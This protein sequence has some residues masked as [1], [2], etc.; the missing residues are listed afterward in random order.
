[1]M[2][3]GEKIKWVC[4][5]I[6]VFLASGILIAP[7]GLAL[8]VQIKEKATI[9]GDVILLKDIASFTPPADPRVSRLGDLELG[10]A[11]YPGQSLALN[12]RYL[13]SR[14]GLALTEYDVKVKVP[15]RLLVSRTA[16]VVDSAAIKRI[17]KHYILNNSSWPSE[18]ITLENITAP[19]KLLLPEGRLDWEVKDRNY[20]GFIGNVRLI[21]IFKVDG[22]PIRKVSVSGRVRVKQ[23]VI[24]A[25]RNLRPGDLIEQEDIRF[26]SEDMAYV[27]K[28]RMI[29]SNAIVG[30]RAVRSIRH[31]Q[32]ITAE[33]VEDPPV[34]QKGSK[35]LIK[36]ESDQILITTIGKALEDGRNGDLVKVVNVSSGK[37]I[38]ARVKGPELVVVSF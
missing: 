25:A 5:L 15:E 36:A 4:G 38:Y 27:P 13:I 21:V 33:M 1:M 20:D 34:V 8:E 14:L 12:S 10:A 22:R 30:K 9:Q 17:F 37:E 3:L 32:L 24:R 2:T 31:D 23:T 19:A 28:Q 35:V 6:S 11:P 26:S 29:N 16:Q 18:D 7:A